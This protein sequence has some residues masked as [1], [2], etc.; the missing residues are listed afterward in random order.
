MSGGFYGVSQ[1]LLKKLVVNPHYNSFRRGYEDM[2]FGKLVRHVSASTVKTIHFPNGQ[3][4]CH[5]KVR[6]DATDERLSGRVGWSASL[7]IK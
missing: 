3:Y 1:A 4:W 2:Q 5:F 6:A 7:C